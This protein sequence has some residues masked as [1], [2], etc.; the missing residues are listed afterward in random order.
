MLQ[1][2]QER[3]WWEEF[4]AGRGQFDRQRQPV[5]AGTDLDDSTRIAGIQLKIWLDCLGALEEEGNGGIVGEELRSRKLCEVRKRQGWDGTF[6]F[7]L[8]VQGGTAG[9]EDAQ[10]GATG[11]QVRQVWGR[12]Q[13]LL[14]VVE[15]EQQALVSQEGFE[16]VQQGSRS[17]IFDAERLGDG[18]HNQAVVA[19]GSE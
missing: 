14:E 9:H 15:Q 5:Q 3:L 16:E 2:G 1:P 7:P 11:Q 4:D 19:D 12:W 13:D 10:V 18:G 6:V 17:A 8:D